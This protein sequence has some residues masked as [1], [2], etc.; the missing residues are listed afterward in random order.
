[1]GNKTNAK[2]DKVDIQTYTLTIDKEHIEDPERPKKKLREH[3]LNI[4]RPTPL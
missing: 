2:T 3:T 4:S 1:M